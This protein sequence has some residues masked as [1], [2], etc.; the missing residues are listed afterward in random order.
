MKKCVNV[1]TKEQAHRKKANI[2]YVSF[3]FSFLAYV[4]FGIDTLMNQKKNTQH[5]HT[6]RRVQANAKK[7]AKCFTNEKK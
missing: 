1:R 2:Y 5:T 3:S 4:L 7:N 6:Q